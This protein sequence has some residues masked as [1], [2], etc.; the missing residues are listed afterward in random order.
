MRPE[1]DVIGEVLL[2]DD[3]SSDDTAS[4]AEHAASRCALPLRVIQ[5]NCRDA[6]GARNLALA[7]ANYPWIYM[8]ECRRSAS[9]RR[10]A[11]FAFPDRYA[12]EGRYGG[13]RLSQTN[14]RRRPADQAACRLYGRQHHQCLSLYPGACTLDCRRKRAGVPARDR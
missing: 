5:S 1:A 13:R 14:R 11:V 9:G 4:V 7:Q 10:A 6:G 12:D 2:V 3:S 8:I